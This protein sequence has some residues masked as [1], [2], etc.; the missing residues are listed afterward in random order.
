MAKACSA[1]RR[2]FG[3]KPKGPPLRG[4]SKAKVHNTLLSHEA[5]MNVAD[6]VFPRLEL[7]IEDLPWI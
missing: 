5:G 4:R 2:H 1:G 7:A 6:G 3:R